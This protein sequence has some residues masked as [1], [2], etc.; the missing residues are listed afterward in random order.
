MNRHNRSA[1]H[2][3]NSVALGLIPESN[4]DIVPQDNKCQYKR[5]IIARRDYVDISVTARLLLCGLE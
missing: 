4:A 5:R 1:K 2:F 3:V